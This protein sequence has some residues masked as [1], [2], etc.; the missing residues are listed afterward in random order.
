MKVLQATHIV[1]LGGNCR[2]TYNLRRTF[3][4]GSA[5]P[6]DWWICP[7]NSATAF[8]TDPDLDALY[9]PALLEPVIQ[10]DRIFSVENSRYRIRLHHEF[11]RTAGGI[12]PTFRDHIGAARA[13]MTYLLDKF[14]RLNSQGNRILFV[15]NFINW[16]AAASEVDTRRFVAA[17]RRSCD[18]AETEFLFLNPSPGGRLDGIATLSFD[19][20]PADPWQGDHAVWRDNLLR[21]NVAFSNREGTRF[22]ETGPE[23]EKKSMDAKGGIPSANR[24][25]ES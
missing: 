8:L 9:D 5:Y 23:K 25:L 12:V 16:D 1:S 4:F 15:R 22:V 3:D 6:F 20:P 24:S 18:L 10:G 13:R 17:A 21:A 14:R 19:D 11:P 2:V 7:L